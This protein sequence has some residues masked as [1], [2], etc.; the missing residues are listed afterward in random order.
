MKQLKETVDI[1]EEFVSGVQNTVQI[2]SIEDLGDNLYKIVTCNT[3]YLFP[4]MEFTVD[5]VDYVVQLDGFVSNKEFIIK[6]SQTITESVI[7]LPP[8][9][10]FHGTVI[11]TVQELKQKQFSKD[12]FPMVYLMETL[13]DQFDNSVG[14]A[15]NRT[16]FLRLFFL[17]ETDE[18]N[19]NTNEHYNYAILP[20]RNALYQFVDTLDRSALIGQFDGYEAVNHAKFGVYMSNVGHTKRIFN[21]RLSG[22]EL[23]INLPIKKSSICYCS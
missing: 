19:W 3:S 22:V 2:K 14:S 23:Q 7:T 6:G 9:K 8:M 16:S 21:D 10:Y 15:I 12:K 1:I 11:A 17:C 18:D 5:D 20:M 13:R 4:M